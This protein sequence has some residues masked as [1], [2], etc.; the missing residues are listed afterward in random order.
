F[1]D[2]VH[3]VDVG[4]AQLTAR[5]VDRQPATDLD[6]I[7]RDEVLGLPWPPQKSNSSNWINVDGLKWSY[8]I[9]VWISVGFRPDCAHSYHRP[10]HLRRTQLRPVVADHRIMIRARP[11]RRRLDDGRPVL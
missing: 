2:A 3:A 9:T 7:V 4:S 10:G 8:R 5:G 11:L 6:S 1:G